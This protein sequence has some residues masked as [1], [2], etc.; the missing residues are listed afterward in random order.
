MNYLISKLIFQSRYWILFVFLNSNFSANAQPF[1]NLESG[2]FFTNI[3]DILISKSMMNT[4][5]F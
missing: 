2:G 1:V 3:N 4:K 5:K